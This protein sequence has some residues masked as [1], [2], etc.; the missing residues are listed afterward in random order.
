MERFAAEVKSKGGI[1]IPEKAAS[2]VLSAT[3]VATGPG[4]RCSETGAILPVSVKEGDRVL[5]PEYGGQKV[6]VG[7]REFVLIRDSDILAKWSD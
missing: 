6:E 2:K 1:M 7:D 5:L 4:A 3:V